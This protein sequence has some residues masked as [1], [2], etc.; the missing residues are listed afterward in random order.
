NEVHREWNS[1]TVD[2]RRREPRF[3]RHGVSPKARFRNAARPVAHIKE[4]HGVVLVPMEEVP[5]KV[6]EWPLNAS[7]VWEVPI[8][9][10]LH[11]E[12]ARVSHTLA[13]PLK[14]SNIPLVAF[15]IADRPDKLQF[16]I[17][18][19]ELVRKLPQERELRFSDLLRAELIQW[20]LTQRA[21]AVVIA[22][23][24]DFQIHAVG[25]RK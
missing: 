6:I 9:S 5:G 8:L 15:G 1:V 2:G 21:S 11:P 20:L 19:P 25:F 12:I 18:L 23:A 3:V 16:R 14:V 24:S 22:F 17:L 4:R 13:N 10:G 7:R